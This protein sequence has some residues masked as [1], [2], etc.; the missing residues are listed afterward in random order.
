MDYGR[1]GF[2]VTDKGNSVVLRLV[3]FTKGGTSETKITLTKEQWEYMLGDL[4][5][6]GVQT[7]IKS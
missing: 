4:V 7:L 6:L 3:S 1:F 2:S 5:K